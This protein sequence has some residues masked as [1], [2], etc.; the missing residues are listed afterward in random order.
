MIST[1]TP[2]AECHRPLRIE[3]ILSEPVLYYGDGM[4]LDGILA[5]AVYAELDERVKRRMP[6]LS[7]H[8]V[9]DLELPLSQWRIDV[10]EQWSGNPLLLARRRPGRSPRTTM[11]WGWCASAEV[12]DWLVQGSAEVRKMPPVDDMIRWTDSASVNVG[13]GEF[14]GHD[15][16]IPSAFAHTVTWYAYGDRDEVERLL[17]EHV[18]AIGRL[19]GHGWGVVEGWT[20]TCD[21][22]EDGWLHDARGRLMRRMPDLA[23]VS[24]GAAKTRAAFRPPYHHHSRVL[25]TVE[26]HP[27]RGR[28]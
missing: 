11:L 12:A 23:P 26:P 17:Q 1:Y 6:P 3:A 16:R 18:Y 2:H 19:R 15:K 25:H 20:V 28:P 22:R 4:H 5:A 10:G 13:S 8:W 21:D 9:S 27:D 24:G 14:K 7:D